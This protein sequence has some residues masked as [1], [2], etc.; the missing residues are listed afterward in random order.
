MGWKVTIPVPQPNGRDKHHVWI[1]AIAHEDEARERL[2]L[3]DIP[4]E[5]LFEPLSSEEFAALELEP[6]EVRR[7]S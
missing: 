4:C 7:I 3:P 1:A 6:G 5:A 2:W